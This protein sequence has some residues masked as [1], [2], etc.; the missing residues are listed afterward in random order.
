MPG[1][2]FFELD[3]DKRRRI[4]DAALR[5]FAAYG[6]GNSSTNRIVRTCGI[7][8]GSLFLYFANKEDLYFYILDTVTAELAAESE[9]WTGSISEELFARI[10]D[11]SAAEIS[12]YIRNPEKGRLLVRAFSDS[13]DAIGARTA[14]RYGPAG[15][16]IYRRLMDG[17]DCGSLRHDKDKAAD[18]VK[19]V[20]AGFNAGFMKDAC[21]GEMSFEKLKDDYLRKLSVYIGILR[22]CL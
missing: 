2:L 1:K 18:I 17:A 14:E 12:W 8:K 3:E 5:E 4:S 21:L 6:Y 9:S 22:D 16:D 7:S 13:S 10:S 11:Y 19:W 15:E 20:L